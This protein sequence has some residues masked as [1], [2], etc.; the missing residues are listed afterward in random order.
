MNADL[1]PEGYVAAG[2]AMGAVLVKIMGLVFRRDERLRR[3]FHREIQELRD[4]VK[5][6]SVQV[7]DWREKYYALVH[8]NLELKNEHARMKQEITV[9]QGAIPQPAPG[10]H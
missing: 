9:L 5:R 8:K 1:G 4:E 10:S 7:D 6:L 2:T 3:E